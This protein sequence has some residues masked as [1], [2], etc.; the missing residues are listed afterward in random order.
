MFWGVE[1]SIQPTAARSWALLGFRYHGNFHFT[2]H[3]MTENFQVPNLGIESETDGSVTLLD[4]LI[5]E[6]PQLA[7]K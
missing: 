5:F 7:G 2:H 6:Q 1:I 4:M 3:G